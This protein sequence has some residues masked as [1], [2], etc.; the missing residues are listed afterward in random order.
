MKIFTQ[1]ADKN[2]AITHCFQFLKLILMWTQHFSTLS[3]VIQTKLIKN[4]FQLPWLNVFI[5]IFQFVPCSVCCIL[6]SQFRDVTLL[7]WP[8]SFLPAPAQTCPAMPLHSGVHQASSEGWLCPI[9]INWFYHPSTPNSS[10]ASNEQ[11][12][13][14]YCTIVWKQNLCRVEVFV[15]FTHCWSQP[16]SQLS[17]SLK[18]QLT[19]R[20]RAHNCFGS[21]PK[22]QD[23]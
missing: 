22:T 17:T 21:L 16:P 19:H 2:Q 14:V 23:L 12:S 11:L 1:R 20:L 15:L 18:F 9:K 13:S 3:W 6:K 7:L 10:Q 4:A 8:G 5:V